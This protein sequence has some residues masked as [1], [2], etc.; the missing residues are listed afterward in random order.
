MGGSQLS[1]APLSLPHVH[2]VPLG[3]CVNLRTQ[4]SRAGYPFL[5]ANLKCSGE[6]VESSRQWLTTSLSA[7][8]LLDKTC[9]LKTWGKLSNS[10]LLSVT[11]GP[12]LSKYRAV[13]PW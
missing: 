3:Q 12:A 7:Q 13:L 11:E 5:Q 8:R 2:Q 4:T 6:K 1:P 10:A 9:N